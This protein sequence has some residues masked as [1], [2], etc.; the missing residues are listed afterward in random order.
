MLTIPGY[1]VTEEIHR[2]AKT[3]LCRGYREQDRCPVIFKTTTEDYPAPKDLARLQHEHALTR[4]WQEE[5]LIRSYA[6]LPYHDTQVL[7]LQDIGGV[8]IRQ[9]LAAPTRPLEFW[10]TLALA[11]ARSL[12]RIHRHRIIHKDINPAN[13]VVNPATGEVQII[14]FGISSQLAR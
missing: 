8:S 6:L 13:L 5:G 12:Q 10:L 3:T 4:D 14:D 2:G 1:Q 11:F 9:L 7:I